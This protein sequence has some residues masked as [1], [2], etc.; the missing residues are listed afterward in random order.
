M[1]D[2]LGLGPCGVTRGGSSPLIRTNILF[3]FYIFTLEKQPIKVELDRQH[4]FILVYT[5]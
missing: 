1:V 3:T 4:Q 5:R 2:A